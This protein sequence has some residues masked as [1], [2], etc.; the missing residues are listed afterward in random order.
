MDK[1][2]FLIMLLFVALNLQAQDEKLLFSPKGI[3]EV[4]ITLDD[5]KQI[6]DIKNEKNDADY[7]GKLN[8]TMIIRNSANS[9]Y[10]DSVL[11]SGKIQIEGRG[12]TTWGVPKKPYNIDLV[13]ENLGEN[14][15]PILGMPVSNEW[16]LLAFWH[17]RSLMRIP[18]AMYLGQQM[19]GIPWTP[20]LRY[21]ELWVND[22][23]RGLYCLS[24]K[25]QRGD[26]RVNLKK[27]TNAADDQTEPRISGGYL[28]E[29]SSE[30]K[31]SDEEIAVDFKTSSDI[32]FSF[33]YPKAK[34]VTSAQRTWILNYLNEFE[35]VLGSHN[36]SDPING[37]QKYMEIPSFIDWTILHEQ[38]KGP[39]NL[40]HASTFVSKERSKK[41]N[42]NAPWDFDLSYANGSDKSEAG[43]MVRTH[44]WFARLADD[45]AYFSQYT[46][47][48]DELRPL[49]YKIPEI[50]EA[51]YQFLNGTGVL[52]REKVR[53]PQILSE[54]S[55]ETY[56]TRPAGY[57]AHVR[58][59][60]DW[61]ASRDAWCYIELGKTD[62]GKADRLKRTKP[63]IRILNFENME[64]GN[65]FYVKIMQSDKDNN[66][67]KYYWNN[68]TTAS[69]NPLKVI[70]SKGKYWVKIAD[71]KGNISQVSDTLY[72]GVEEPNSLNN[73][74]TEMKFSYT[75]PATDLLTINYCSP[76]NYPECTVSL[77]DLCGIKAFEAKFNLAESYNQVQIPVA[78]LQRGIYIL[79]LQAN[80]TFVSKKIILK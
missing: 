66:L 71:N 69:T 17:D 55:P 74:K 24:E 36:F 37:Y 64:S 79:R 50:L 20:H 75:N 45:P 33:K 16:A 28:L 72:F 9:T 58:Y 7:V 77:W 63:I 70:N 43:N 48:F 46:A 1:K 62:Q 44:R 78:K 60:S 73:P 21:A 49:L 14:P 5:G 65:P 51:N 38:S 34:N 8:G 4:H 31:L 22:E 57:H 11:Y 80:E 68:S 2:S 53:W 25:V 6:D 47:R 56:M 76:V 15:A 59:L 10:A 19:A 29:G 3:A 12:N 42:M 18:L 27:L 35:S 67:F 54:Y 26:D 39:D 13:D 23:Y 61:I 32:N 52:D 40:F 30:E 41:L